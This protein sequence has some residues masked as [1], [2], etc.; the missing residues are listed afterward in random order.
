MSR[1]SGR[2]PGEPGDVYRTVEDL[3][4]RFLIDTDTASDDAIAIMM[5]LRHP[6]VEVEVLTTVA[7]NVGV[8][9]ATQ[10]A[11]YTT[12]LCGSDVPV[13]VGAAAPMLRPLETAQYVH[14]HDGMGDCGLDLAGRQPASGR[15]V[16][17]IVE[18]VLGSPSEITI[19]AIGPLTNIAIALLRAPEIATVVKRVVIMGGTGVHGPGNV[20]PMAE[21]NFW[22]DPEA[23]RIVA[24]S[25]MP[26]EIVG[27]DASIRSALITAEREA[28]IRAI[29]TKFS[30][31][32]LDISGAVA[33][34]TREA[35]LPGNDLP[36]PIAMAHAIDPSISK[37]T[38]LHVDV[39]VGDGPQR[40][41]MEVDRLGFG[42][43]SPNIDL[44]ADVASDRFFAML[45]DAC[46]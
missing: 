28:R 31:F 35:G 38:R 44:V 27:W 22:V 9:Q 42:G 4:Q 21:F 18:T 46:R 25:G 33:A 1:I 15:G 24:R 10:N 12:E 3:L 41:V 20:T 26:L 16:D 40:G 39:M 30:E 17:V 29:D 19:V 5:A 13:H 32:A 37:M 14:G 7:G 45:H 43:A 36:D 2:V 34:F 6:D 8:E 11:L 23:A